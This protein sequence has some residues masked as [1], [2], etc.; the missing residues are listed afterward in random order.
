MKISHG[1]QFCEI[2]GWLFGHT[3]TLNHLYLSG[4]KRRGQ[5]VR[6]NLGKM[7]LW[8]RRE[9]FQGESAC[10]HRWGEKSLDLQDMPRLHA[11]EQDASNLPQEQAGDRG[12]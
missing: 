12:S 11:E 9:N 3:Y 2:F 4:R 5:R 8:S 10:Q 1:L 7:C 6:V